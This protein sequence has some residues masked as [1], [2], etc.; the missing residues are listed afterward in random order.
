M[1][2]LGRGLRERVGRDGPG[3]GLC[4]RQGQRVEGQSTAGSRRGGRA[5]SR[6]AAAAGGGSTLEGTG[7]WSAHAPR[8][9]CQQPLCNRQ[10][11][12]MLTGPG[13]VQV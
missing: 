3:P 5:A 1:M 10:V 8:A 4:R 13:L 9:G 12:T 2:A 6:W 7:A 11:G